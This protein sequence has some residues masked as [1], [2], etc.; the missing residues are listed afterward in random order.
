MNKYGL[1]DISSV[2]HNLNAWD[3][4]YDHSNNSLTEKDSERKRERERERERDLEV[5]ASKNIDGN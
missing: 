2:T 3:L 1:R 5:L 4:W